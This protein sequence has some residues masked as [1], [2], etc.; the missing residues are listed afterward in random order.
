VV[1]SSHYSL[2][3]FRSANPARALAKLGA[4]VVAADFDDFASLVKALENVYIEVGVEFLPY[5]Y[6]NSCLIIAPQIKIDIWA[7]RYDSTWI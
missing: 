4:D 6:D 7:D 5:F 2:F 1:S 3:C